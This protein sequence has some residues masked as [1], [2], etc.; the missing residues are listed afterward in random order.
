[1]TADELLEH[2]WRE[3]CNMT[4]VAAPLCYVDYDVGD[5]RLVVL[6]QQMRGDPPLTWWVYVQDEAGTLLLR[7]H[8]LTKTEL[9]PTL[10]RAMQVLY[11]ESNTAMTKSKLGLRPD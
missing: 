5:R 7:L 9:R 1:M 10:M 2:A 3:A 8:A 4:A 6:V 11:P